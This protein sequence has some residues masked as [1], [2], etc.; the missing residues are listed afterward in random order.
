MTDHLC[1]KLLT[2]KVHF[3]GFPTEFCDFLYENKVI[4]DPYRHCPS[5]GI[6]GHYIELT[7]LETYKLVKLFMGDSDSHFI[8]F[9]TKMKEDRPQRIPCDNDNTQPNTTYEGL[10]CV[11]GFSHHSDSSHVCFA[12]TKENSYISVAI[13]NIAELSYTGKLS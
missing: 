12:H 7:E 11:N 13:N 9:R 1:D 10:W 6:S 8:S 5:Y 4:K 2:I 3:S